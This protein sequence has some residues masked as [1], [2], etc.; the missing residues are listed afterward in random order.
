MGEGEED[1]AA[2]RP[3]FRSF[4]SAE[5]PCR[6]I[7]GIISLAIIMQLNIHNYKLINA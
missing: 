4:L 7:I 6:V 5:A 3:C 1:G 2:Q